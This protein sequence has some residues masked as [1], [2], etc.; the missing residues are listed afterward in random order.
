MSPKAQ[1]TIFIMSDEHAS[2]YLGCHGHRQVKTP[3]MDALAARGTR[4]SNAYTNAPICMPARAA[5]ATGRY[6]HQTGYW[7]NA[8]PYDGQPASW[9]HRLQENGVPVTSIGKL[10]YRNA[11]T[12]TGFD[13]TIIPMFAPRGQGDLFGAIRDVAPLP[14]R[15]KSD[16]VANEI[17][18]GESTYTKYDRDI[19]ARTVDWLAN[20]PEDPDTP[21]VLYVGLVAPHFPLIAPQQFYD[22]YPLSE[23]DLPKACRPDDWPD[24]PWFRAF[25]QA[26]ITDTFFDDDKR[27][28]AIASYFGLCSFLDD[29]IGQ[30]VKAVDDAGLSDTTRIVYTSD[31]GDNLGVRGLWQKSNFYEESA[32]VPLIM[33]GP[34]IAPGKVVDTPV[35]IIDYHPTILTSGGVDTSTDDL[36]GE[37][38][39]DIADRPYDPNRTVFGEYH[40]AGAVSGVFMLRRDTLKYV[41]YVGLPP[42][43]FDLATD[44]EELNDLAGDPAQ[45]AVLA[46]FETHLRGMLYPEDVDAQAKAAQ[47]QI[48][49]NAGGRDAILQRGTFGAS[50]PP[51]ESIQFG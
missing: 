39:F 51:G 33:S 16:V 20:R 40:G 31:H 14:P 22:M 2:K 45:A 49:Q 29:N 15:K 34:D 26:Y 12:S 24:H 7:C 44:P 30:I 5:F 43:L 47:R 11:D 37:S 28:I 42:Q 3:H 32:A 8:S 46:A 18:P 41:H 48:I 21:W 25:R 19:T 9:A 38:L 35:S 10:H 1:N 4:F 36:P 27:R 23:I 6:P 17:G 13:D 50:P